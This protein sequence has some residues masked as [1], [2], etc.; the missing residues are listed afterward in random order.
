M[1]A[2]LDGDTAA[3]ETLYRRHRGPVYRYVFRLLGERGD[4]ESVFQ[5]TWFKLIRHRARWRR[6]Q[7]WKPWLY[8]IAHNAAVDAMRREH[9][10]PGDGAAEVADSAPAV[11]RWQ[12]IRDCIER[13]LSL[14]RDLPAEQREAFLL[15]HEAGLSL[16][17]IAEL[18][19]VGRET[20]K[21]RLRY[22][23][24]RLRTGLEGCDN[25]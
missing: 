19:G 25:A 16:Q 12:F 9:E 6:E 18:A 23:M 1:L 3:F 8:R 22:V 10:H 13:L 14:L 2:Y 20:V 24:R 4:P 11:E 21:S 17:E 15:Q 7:P 5:E